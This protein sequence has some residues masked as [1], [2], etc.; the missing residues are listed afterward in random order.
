MKP[1]SPGPERFRFQ[2]LGREHAEPV[3]LVARVGAHHADALALLEGAID[4]AQQH[5]HPEVSVVPT[6]NEQRFQGSAA[7]ALGRRQPRDDRLQH[8]VDVEAR[9]GRDQDRVR[10]IEADHVL[11]LL[12]DLVGLGSRQVDLV[13]DRHDLMIVVE[14]LVD[15]GEG[16]R[17]DP[18]AGVD[19]QERAFAGGEAAVHFVSKVDVP[20]RVDQVEDVVLAVARM[21]VEPD[22]LGLDGDAALALDIHGIEHLL[23]P[24]HL[25]I[26][27]AAGALNEPVRKRRLA[28]IDVGDDGEIADIFDGLR[29]H[30]PHVAMPGPRWK[31]EAAAMAG[32]RRNRAAGNPQPAC[33]G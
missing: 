22:R 6:V 17:L 19:D 3:D 27:E 12:L 23:A 2:H 5:H 10:R 13:E 33:E 11:D 1:I 9:L 18:L 30:G 28:V 16:L 14:G 25:A 24:Q 21:V 29:R 20:G 31:P 32:A 4:H 7:V 26:R 8:I 15:V